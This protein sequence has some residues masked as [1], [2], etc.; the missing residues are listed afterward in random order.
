MLTPVGQ[1]SGF[2][3]ELKQNPAPWEGGSKADYQKTLMVG[4]SE[5]V[6]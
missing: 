3:K 2:Q 4:F 1:C 6:K 5:W